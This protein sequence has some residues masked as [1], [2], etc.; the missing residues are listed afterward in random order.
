MLELTFA[1]ASTVAALAS[2]VLD[3]EDRE[4]LS[5][6]ELAASSGVIFILVYGALS[7]I[8]DV[9]RIFL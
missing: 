4:Y 3:L 1:A 6:G 9:G 2:Y 7:G 8:A 5:P